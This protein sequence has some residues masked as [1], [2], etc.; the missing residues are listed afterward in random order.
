MDR[1]EQ[2]SVI[3]RGSY[4]SVHLV[5]RKSD[6]KQLVMK[7]VSLFQFSNRPV[8]HIILVNTDEDRFGE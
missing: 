6:G 7:K 1:Y 5:K 4:G 3:G 2:E 8:A